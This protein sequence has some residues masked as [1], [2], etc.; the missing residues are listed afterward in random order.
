MIEHGDR[1][2]EAFETHEN[3]TPDPAEVYARVQQLAKS[4]QRRRWGVQAAGGAALG[5][6][7]IA[8]VIALPGVLPGSSAAAPV[9]APAAGPASGA[10]KPSA[11]AGKPYASAEPAAPNQDLLDKQWTAF[12]DAG[13]VYSDAVRLA[14]LWHMNA[15]DPSAAKAEAGR[16]L[17]AGK[18]LPFKPDPAN[19]A[20]A[21]ESAD[22]D[23]FLGAGYTYDQAVLLAK[24]W[25]LKDASQA[26]IAGGQRLRAG[27]T[28]PIKP[29][30]ANKPPTAA[31]DSAVTAFFNAGYTYAD[32][33]QLAQIWKTVSPYAAKIAGGKK[34]LAGQTLPIKP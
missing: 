4:Y 15:S 29:D 32:A 31:D 7:L 9:V 6:S 2:R 8:G 30:P 21:Q 22:I 23:A 26:K 33:V 11:G 20:A 1:L 10:G 27:E 3:T 25:H 19:V 13:Y 24:L 17:L 34:L 18:P 5:A 14:T 16:R 12:A 28:L